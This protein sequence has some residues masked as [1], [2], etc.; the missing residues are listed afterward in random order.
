[1]NNSLPGMEL[2]ISDFSI[3]DIKFDGPS[4]EGVIDITAL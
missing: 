1:M 4:F 2:K 3:I